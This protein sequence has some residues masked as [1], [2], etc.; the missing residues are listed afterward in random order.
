[1]INTRASDDLKKEK[2]LPLVPRAYLFISFKAPYDI[3][4]LLRFLLVDGDEDIV[5][6]QSF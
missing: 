1:M 6:R 2:P 4:D 5:L 3:E